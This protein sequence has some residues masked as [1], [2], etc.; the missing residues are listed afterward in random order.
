MSIDPCTNFTKLQHWN[1][2]VVCYGAREKFD[3]RQDV[4]INLE[5]S[6]IQALQDIVESDYSPPP[7]RDNGEDD[8]LDVEAAVA[9]ETLKELLPGTNFSDREANRLGAAVTDFAADL[10]D[11]IFDTPQDELGDGKRMTLTQVSE[12]SLI[13]GNEKMIEAL[14][15]DVGALGNIT[16]FDPDTIRRM[17]ELVS[18]T[19]MDVVRAHLVNLADLSLGA[20]VAKP[21]PKSP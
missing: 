10:S 11:L 1:M 18:N 7:K 3:V 5:E 4:F 21:L 8:E 12:L 6:T 9:A 20:F 14:V 16:V 17:S 15:P 13:F 2:L 19:P